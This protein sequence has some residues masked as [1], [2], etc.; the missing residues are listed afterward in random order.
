LTL[1]P[2]RD[3]G[4]PLATMGDCCIDV[5]ATEGFCAV[6]GNALNVA[7]QWAFSGHPALYFGAVGGDDAGQAVQHAL[8][9]A[10]V[11]LDGLQ[12]RDGN[13]G[14]TQ[15]E[16]RDD[17]ER[18]LAHEDFG[19]AADYAPTEA[20]IARLEGAR[21]LHAAT[22]PDLR[23][24]AAGAA[25][26]SVPV[27]YDFSTRHETEALGDLEVAFFSWDG[28]PG[29][30]AVDLARA[31]LAGG[32]TTVVV[33][34]GRHGSLAATR[35]EVHVAS[36]VEAPVVDTCGAGDSFVAAFVLATL[37]GAPLPERMEAAAAAAAGT[38]GHLGAWPQ[39]LRRITE[40][41][42]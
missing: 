18:V 11:G 6:G 26:R 28:P 36:A 24:V 23:G 38:C 35:D 33:T 8:L 31:A 30:G 41:S 25:A 4:A 21:W 12:V 37:A 22:L 17:G 32:A 39:D 10:G 34:C 9:D 1:P 7:V 27:S 2:S 13:T 3:P 14:V 20:D 16:L 19:V 15:I 40:R 42:L 29:D 5:Y